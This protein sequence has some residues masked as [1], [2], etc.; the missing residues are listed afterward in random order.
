MAPWTTYLLEPKP[1]AG[2]HF[3]QRGLEQEA[4]GVHCPSDT[5]FAA[6][7]ATVA[8]LEGEAG[9]AAFVAPFEGGSPPFLLTSAFPRAGNL[10]LLPAPLLRMELSPEPGR[11]KLLKRLRYVSPA[12]LRRMMAGQP[13]D[14]YA[15][16][17]GQGLFLQ[18]GR[19]WITAGEVPDLPPAWQSLPAGRLRA[20]RIWEAHAVDRVAVD[21]AASAS[22]IYRTGR[23]I[24]APGCGLWLAAQWPAGPGALQARL[25]TL[26]Q[27][28]GDRGLGGERSVG[29]GQFRLETAAASLDLPAAGP[30]GPQLT[31]ARYLPRP[32]ELPAALGGAAAYRLVPVAGWLYAPGHAARR[33]RQ[34]RMLAEGSVFEPVGPGPWGRVVDVAPL[35]WDGYPIWRYGYA[36]PL[37]VASREV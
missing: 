17:D 27:H 9:A 22:S 1:G 29:Y 4:S 23:T 11:R 15:A 24:Y 31:L 14:D 35:D 21:R 36:C 8:D 18:D 6:L 2:F 32:G 34:V 25:E 37:G 16:A 20:Q 3:G 7:V 30:G 10:P 13:L 19:V 33:R 5:L 28:L 26:L 12:L